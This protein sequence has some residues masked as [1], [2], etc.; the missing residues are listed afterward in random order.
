MNPGSRDLV[1]RRHYRILGKIGGGPGTGTGI[2][3]T[4]DP[5]AALTG[6]PPSTTILL[7][8]GA[9][10]TVATRH[11]PNNTR[12]IGD[13]HGTRLTTATGFTPNT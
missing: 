11:I 4:G 5:F 2:T 13:E 7:P 1:S 10:G 12:I 3:C 8:S 6:P 9:I